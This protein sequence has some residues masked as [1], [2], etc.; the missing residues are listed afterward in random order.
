MPSVLDAPS[1]SGRRRSSAAP[2]GPLYAG[3]IGQAGRVA[4]SIVDPAETL[5]QSAGNIGAGVVGLGKGVV[6]AVENFPVVGSIAKPII[7]AVGGIADATIGNVVKAAEGVRIGEKTLAEKGG[8]AFDVVGGALGFGLDVLTAPAQFVEQQIAQQRIKGS[9]SGRRDLSNIIFGDAPSEAINSVKAGLPI[10][11]AALKLAKSNAGFSENGA[12]NFLYSAIL[13]PMVI[14]L[15]GVGK[16]LSAAKQA[17]TLNKIGVS[18]LKAAGLVQDAAFAEKWQWLG[19]IYEGTLGKAGQHT[20]RMSSN[21]VKESAL[22]WTRVHD[23]KVIGSFLDEIEAIGG[24]ALADRGLKNYAATFQ[25]AIKSGAVRARSTIVRSQSQDFADNLVTQFIRALKGEEGVAKMTKEQLLSIPA[26]DGKSIGQVLKRLRVK[27]DIITKLTD[28]LDE[29]VARNIR[30]DELR[31]KVVDQRNAIEEAVANARIRREADLIL[32]TA[33]YRANGNARLA[34]EDAIRILREAKNDRIPSAANLERGRPELIQDLQAGFGLDE[35]SATKV[36]D[37]VFAKNSGNVRAIADV[38]SMAR[39]A[40]FGQAMKKLAV[41]RNLFADD[42]L[43]SR[44]TITSSR[45]ITRSE[46]ERLIAET[47]ELFAIVEKGG[48]GVAAAK[49]R[50]KDIADDLVQKYDEFG[51]F[52]GDDYDYTQVITFLNKTKNMAVRELKDAER[53]LISKQ[54]ASNPSVRQL[55]D[56]EAEL[57]Q[58][59]YRLGI[60]PKRG[61]GKV[62]TLVPDHH[63]RER[64]VEMVM[65]FSDTL[66]HIAIKNLDDALVSERLRPTSLSRIWDGMTRPFGTEVTKNIIIERFVTSMVQKTGISV[67][68][69]RAIMSKVTS[70]A[71]EKEIQPR[72]LFLDS[73]AVNE[74]FRFEM[75]DAYGRLAE[76]GTTPIKEII[77]ASAGDLSSAGLTSGFTGRVKAIRPEITILTDRIYPEVRFGRLNPFFNL[78]LERIE[79]T[80]MRLQYG[81]KKEVAKQGVGDI[82]GS[83]LRKAHLDPRNVNREITDGTMDVAARAARNT[84]AAV[85]GSPNFTKRVTDKVKSWKLLSIQGVKDT[86]KVARDIMTDKL[87]AREFIDTLEEVAPGKLNELAAHYGVTKADEVVER[88]LNDYLVQ[89]DPILFARMVKSEGVAARRLA[90]QSLVKGGLTKKQANDIAGA[91]IA[92]YETAMLRASRAADKAQYFASHRTWLERSVNHPFLGLYPYSYMVQKAVPSLLRYLFL[93]PWTKG[94]LAPGLGFEKFEQVLEWMNNTSN[95]DADVVK[96]IVSND[97]VLYVFSSI[98]PVTPDAMGFSAPTWLRRGIIQPGLRGTE[99]TPGEF[100]PTLSE[101]G[102]TVV[103]GTVL[104][105]TRTLIEGIQG[106]DDT[107]RT[108]ESIGGFIQ[109]Q[110]ENIQEQVSGLRNP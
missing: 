80:I 55:V 37:G 93:T 68:S 54:A 87:A 102:S 24:R 108:N 89:S 26:A 107:I 58:Y 65:P 100:A 63:G 98:L 12:I 91:T 78:V 14:I 25:N 105:Q 31:R 70:L 69:A 30:S 94:N 19:K 21:I 86:K 35:I 1:G 11:E 17:S 75:K 42:A 101:I 51:V 103:R 4:V 10:E 32:T 41:L 106:V 38:L 3:D 82:Q 5:K 2:T 57:A 27:D 9:L 46:A 110:V 62:T 95:S 85:A 7:G 60:S 71:A 67:R 36:A 81:I 99:I 39:G 22:G 20:R 92:A 29:G 47:D 72:A 13:D 109:D 52:A 48:E 61:V 74:I 84:A 97:A 16:G 83:L 56:T 8:E 28:T 34:S 76:A 73:D 64:I 45:S 18:T 50:L 59:G 6:S 33:K 53:S 96:D 79:T 104:G 88:L 23:T 49:N 15:P 66:D 90:T 43:L 44:L 40:A 77:S